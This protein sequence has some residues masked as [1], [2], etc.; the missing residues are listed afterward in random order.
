MINHYLTIAKVANELQNNCIGNQLTGCHS[1]RKNE[2]LFS[3][4]DQQQ[5]SVFLTPSKP[6]VFISKPDSVPSKNV[7][8]FFSEIIGLSLTGVM[9]HRN[10][11]ILKL[12]FELEYTVLIRI[13]SA[14]SGIVLYRNSS[15]VES[16]KN[17]AEILAETEFLEISDALNSPEL[18]SHSMAYLPVSPDKI[19]G[20]DLI[21]GDLKNQHS[22]FVYKINQKEY[23][24]PFQLKDISYEKELSRGSQEIKYFALEKIITE[25]FN[26]EK[27]EI[28]KKLQ[29]RLDKI[30]GTIKQLENYLGSSKDSETLERDANLLFSQQD[31]NLKGLSHI[32]LQ[33]IL[34]EDQEEVTIKL[35]PTLT[36]QE[37]AVQIFNRI[38]NLREAKSEKLFLLGKKKSE[39]SS[40]LITVEEFEL[41]ITPLQLKHFKKQN[42]GMFREKNQM[43]EISEPFHRVMSRFG[44]E[45]LIGKHAKGNDFLLTKV[46]GK[47]DIWLHTKNSTG[48]HVILPNHSKEMPMKTK[49]EEAAA[50]A[51][52][53]SSQKKSD[54][55]PV[56]YTFSK[57]VR[58]IKGSAPG[59]VVVDKEDVLFVK[60]VKP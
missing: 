25:N 30:Q 17:S 51:A 20:M 48:S 39:W 28:H 31:V 5:F 2:F 58:K 50:F 56:T 42:S 7:F 26:R 41:I 32:S 14:S 22:Y 59:A 40:L 54:W 52:F 33:N 21:T 6:F 10:D 18:L 27:K 45:I 15:I 29:S 38:K 24:F 35:N 11:R 37:N 19:P 55:V 49:I 23:L 12:N 46:S 57:Y 53:F 47:N 8:H 34:S 4:S 1:Y 36:L 44:Y 16:V 3:F 60:P 13:F 43:Q 9:I